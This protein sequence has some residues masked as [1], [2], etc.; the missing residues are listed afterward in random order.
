M[1][2]PRV[3]VVVPTIGRPAELEV[4]L[5]HLRNLEHDAFEI[6]V[7]DNSGGSVAIRAIAEKAGARYVIEPC[8]GVSAA[9]NTGARIA[10][11][12]VLAFIDDNAWP[13]PGWLDAHERA[14]REDPTL[15]ATT[16]R[17]FAWP[18]RSEGARLYE[19]FGGEDLGETP[20]R[21]DRS[22]ADWF[23]RANFGGVGVG[24]NMVFRRS[25]FEQ[26]WGFRESLGP[27]RGIAGEEHYAFYTLLRDGHAIAY[28]PDAVVHHSAPGSEAAVHARM[29]RIVD[30]GAV[31]ALLLLIEARG[32]RRRLLRHIAGRGHGSES[33]GRRYVTTAMLVR[34]LLRA[35]LAYAVWRLRWRHH[36]AVRA[37]SVPRT[38]RA[39]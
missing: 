37:R 27:A 26:G 39:W 4:C 11:G 16:G 20:F 23:V 38:Q 13:E 14:L 28:L 18:P 36:R 32:N 10:R 1:I 7:V 19:S 9:R 31:Y 12:D 35:P 21:I 34:A 25:L 6:V 33:V 24:P 3:S 8:R 29:R 17:I 30:G 2:A 15:A 5:E 22:A